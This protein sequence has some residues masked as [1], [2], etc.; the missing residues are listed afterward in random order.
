MKQLI[1]V[2][3]LTLAACAGKDGS[4]GPMGQSGQSGESCTAVKSGTVTT[5]TCDNSVV[6]INDGTNGT[7]GQDA[8]PLTVVSTKYCHK[9]V[10]QISL[11]KRVS[12]FSNGM[13]FVECEVSTSVGTYSSSFIYTN[14]Q[15][16]YTNEGCAV[17][18]DT[19]GTATAGWWHFTDNK[20]KYNDGGP[21]TPVEL[22]CAVN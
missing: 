1:F 18:A 13:K 21:F 9:F 4:Q 6:T 10:G 2:L 8:A 14:S 22:D 19:S 16:G 3:I 20:A 11:D 15:V 5:V 17:T 12:T 7:N